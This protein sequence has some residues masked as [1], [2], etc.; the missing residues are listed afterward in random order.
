MPETEAEE[1]GG[2]RPNEAGQA[3]GSQTHISAILRFLRMRHVSEDSPEIIVATAGSACNAGTLRS[4]R[5]RQPRLRDSPQPA[6]RAMQR[7]LPFTARHRPLLRRI[8][9]L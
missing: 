7:G 2:G 6:P 4:A 1:S 3:R 5:V 8:G 9:V